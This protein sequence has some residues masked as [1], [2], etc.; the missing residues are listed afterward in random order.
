V[1]KLLDF[2][3]AKIRLDQLASVESAGL[4]KTGAMLGSPLYMSPEQAQG[5]KTI[6]ARTDLWSLGVVLYQLLSGKTPHGHIDTMGGLILAIC[7]QPP[8][9]VQDHAP[10]V[11]PEAA[12]IVHRALRI[13]VASRFQS[14]SEML[15]ALRAQLPAGTALHEKS[16]VPMTEQALEVCAPRL[17]IAASNA[18]PTHHAESA[19]DATLPDPAK[20]PGATTTAGVA[21]PRPAE[22]KRSSILYYGAAALVVLS[23][24]GFA[25]S[26]WIGAR[27]ALV[28]SQAPAIQAAVPSAAS[29][30][31]PAPVPVPSLSFPLGVPAGSKVDID[32]VSTPVS[33]T[34]VVVNGPPGSDHAVHVVLGKAESSTSVHVTNGGLVP[35]R[36]VLATPTVVRAPPNPSPIGQPQ[37]TNKWNGN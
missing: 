15:D 14:A 4:T 23:G 10:W 34:A 19:F 18:L 12:A 28:P 32:G 29:S 1:V 16:L 7:S 37:I 30:A 22:T 36:I 13:D 25:A 33:G 11:A 6:D 17:E 35:D 20:V 2:G 9:L 27:A 26:R 3:I 21:Q 8:R 5:A 24:G 31:P